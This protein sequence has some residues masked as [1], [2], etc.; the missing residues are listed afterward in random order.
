MVTF[1]GFADEAGKSVEE[2]IRATLES[3]WNAIEVRNADGVNFT[4]ISDEVFD[5]S[6]A[7]MEEAGVRIVG[8]GSQIANWG[9]PIDTDFRMDVEEL[10]RATPRKPASSA[11]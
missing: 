3:G 1:S 10:R 9:R 8:F 11:S 6:L 4:D 2:Q 5:Q 7:K